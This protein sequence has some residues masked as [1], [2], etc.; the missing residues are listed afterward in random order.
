MYAYENADQQ[1]SATRAS[2]CVMTKVVLKV[3]IAKPWNPPR[4][5]VEKHCFFLLARQN[6]ALAIE[7]KGLLAQLCIVRLLICHH[8]LTKYMKYYLID[9]PITPDPNDMRAVTVHDKTYT[10]NDILEMIDYRK[11][12]LSRSQITAPRW[13][14]SSRRAT[15]Y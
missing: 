11:V 13:R 9:N 1:S 10:M 5:G 3:G 8:K 12:G 15:K 2:F 4:A 14:L 6:A 7:Q